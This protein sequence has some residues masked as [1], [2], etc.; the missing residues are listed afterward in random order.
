MSF[1]KFTIE[2]GSTYIVNINEITDV[3]VSQDG[4]ARISFSD[5]DNYVKIDNFPLG[6]FEAAL[7]V[8]GVQCVEIKLQK[9][10]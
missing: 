4:N 7:R 3:T 10:Q 1:I 8:L 9:K 5:I 2:N 6:E